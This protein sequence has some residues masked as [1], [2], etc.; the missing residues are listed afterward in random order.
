MII[1]K[2]E[3]TAAGE[4]ILIID[5]QQDS[6][7]LLFHILTKAGY[8]V[9]PANNG[10]LGLEAVRVKPPGLILLDIRMPNMDGFE[11][12]KHLKSK[13]ESR[14]IPV[15]FLSALKDTDD[16]AMGFKLGAVD[17]ITK[18]FD[19]DEVLVR[20]KTHL[21]NYNAQIKLE[22][23]YKKI[24]KLNNE[25]ENRVKERTAE[26]D[27]Q[28]LQ[29]KKIS[30]ENARLYKKSQEEINKRKKTEEKLI[31]SESLLRSISEN[32]PAY[33]S[34][35]EKDFT[36]GYTAGKEFKKRNLNPND[37]VG[38]TLDDVFADNAP[39]VKE[40]YKKAF[41]GE[42]VS[43]EL[44]L[45]DLYQTYYT[46][47]LISSNGKI[48]RIL[49]F[50][51]NNT[52]RKIVENTLY[53]L[54]QKGW[55][56]KN[57]SFFQSLTEFLSKTLNI[58]Y[59]FI[60]IIK[61][62]TAQ[63]IATYA[64]DK[65]VDNIEYEI[66]NTPC[67]NVAAKQLCIY[68]K[69]IQKL[70]PEDTLLTD[71]G[72]ESYAGIPL[73][74]SKGD[75]SG[76]IALIGRKPIINEPL[77]KNVLQI[78][79]VRASAELERIKWDAELKRSEERFRISLQNSKITVFTQDLEQKYTWVYNP[80]SDISP[81]YVV[82]KTD[83]ELIPEDDAVPIMKLKQE[84]LS[85]GKSIEQIVRFTTHDK[86]SYFNTFLEPIF[87]EN[88][89]VSGLSGTSTDITADVLAGEAL[90][91]SE[92]RYS[93]AQ[94]AG[95]IGSWDWDMK[96]GNLEW[97][98]QIE[99]IF[100]F[101]TGE[102]NRT[103]DSFLQSVHPDDRQSV[104]DSVNA[105]INDNAEYNI[106]HRITWPN[107]TVRWVM[108]TGDIYRNQKGQAI[109]MLGIVQDI[110]TRK[111]AE[112]EL[113]K[114]KEQL[115][116]LVKK[117][118]ADLE[119]YRI[120][121]SHINDLA[122]ICDANGKYMYLNN[123]FEK[124]TNRKVEEFIGKSF[125]PL[126]KEESLENAINGYKSTLRGENSVYEVSFKDSGII[127]EFNDIPLKNEK[128]KIIG[129]IGIG[130]DITERKRMEDNTKLASQAKSKF[131]TNMSHELRTPLNSILGITQITRRDSSLPEKHKKSIEI[132]H[133]SGEYLLSLIKQVLDLAKAEAGRIDIEETK[134]DLYTMLNDLNSSFNN[135][136]V[137]KGLYFNYK[138]AKE[139]PYCVILDEVKLRQ[140]LTNLISNAIKFTREG[141]VL[142][143]V[144]IKE[145]PDSNT[146]KD[147]L[148]LFEIEDT[149]IGL[150]Q[151]EIGLIFE[152]FVQTSIQKK[153]G[154]GLGLAISYQYV[155]LLGGELK[156]K[157]KPDK[158]S[159]F[160]FNI[161]VRV[162]K[163]H[164]NTEKDKR[165]IV[166][167]IAPGQQK[168]KILI[169]DDSEDNRE[170]ILMLLQSLDLPEGEE[171][172]FTVKTAENG[173]QAVEIF[174][175]WTPDLIFM[176]IVMPVMNG[177]DA[178]RQIKSSNSG[179]DTIVIALTAN[180]LTEDINKMVQTGFSKIIHK[181][182]HEN[183][184]VK[185]LE[186]YLGTKFTFKEGEKE[187]LLTLPK[188]E[189]LNQLPK[190]LLFKLKTAIEELNVDKSKHLLK[191]IGYTDKITARQLYKLI[192]DFR[193]DVL[194]KIILKKNNEQE[195]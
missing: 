148:L 46:V 45:N 75:L 90:R 26:L 160:Y 13:R 113:K 50:V 140:I 133:R 191:E 122:Y 151:N 12:C 184:I 96:T 15:I 120:L 63:T 136:I 154:T 18:P 109:R 73:W 51:V 53:F 142:V 180:V 19:P 9:R 155:K 167:G 195:K 34:V 187:D 121:F 16:K 130:R 21:T 61:N 171:N 143:N 101:K 29:Q 135:R 118:T 68:C 98:E 183:D 86:P 44:K 104:I 164:K 137:E 105:S 170:M 159:K 33:L 162:L 2:L 163:E 100:G 3:N 179:N 54:A 193:F 81:E 31:E 112:N 125:E 115:E 91:K 8:I 27:R 49:A 97:S 6:L 78:V 117:R 131:L 185:V 24:A 108:E 139:V 66:K 37:Y 76:L 157:S 70:F 67:E 134:C 94:R 168:K 129:V 127:C 147:H 150:S 190:E 88:G 39:K 114:Y 55:D 14:Q 93:L 146:E 22:T 149:G 83:A 25:L 103:Y 102:F 43:F 41:N 77:V 64:I 38:H 42:E 30:E 145:N 95:N 79:A 47:P 40:Y 4:D 110:T 5:D 177:Y 84:V 126:F 165:I 144:G 175:E 89:N 153:E 186:E 192:E 194:Q 48:D 189:A 82:G 36:I 35:I 172:P 119:N 128:G 182:F 87:N 138:K 10:K 32:L 116:E 174:N 71:F 74:D 156:V 176:D 173:K 92:E 60:D 161:P 178:Y 69:D 11:V 62:G 80:S 23:A 52:E 58:E 85:S 141:G 59:A 99:P 28:L 65:I 20:V 158:G 1:E 188:Q 124:L 132:I 166:E 72:A 169:V 111:N 7:Q 57:G 106:E 107:G 123:T 17:Y 181:P 152:P 56:K